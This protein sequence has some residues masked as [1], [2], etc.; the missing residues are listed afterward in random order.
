VRGNAWKTTRLYSVA[1]VLVICLTPAARGAVTFGQLDDFQDGTAMGWAEGLNTTSPNPPINMATG[2]R[3]GAG[4]RFLQ[5]ASSGGFGA[6]SKQIMFNEGR[7][8]G[9]YNAARV[10][11][12][13]GWMANAGA[14]TLRV[15]VAL[16]GAGSRF[17]STDPVV[18]APR[19]NQSDPLRWIPVTFDLT[20]GA[21]T[22]VMGG[23][24]L[25]TARSNVTELRLLSSASPSFFGDSLVSALAVDDLRALHLQ[26]DTDF[27]GRVTR[28]EL[29][30][31]R[32]NMG[33]TGAT[34]QTGD[35]N[36]DGRVNALDMALLRRNF[37]SSPMSPL[38]AA[39]IVPE[40]ACSALPLLM[41]FLL[42]RCRHTRG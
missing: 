8:A 5:N 34:W 14:S 7:W 28:A 39:S 11:R 29:A 6:G 30:L 20:A 16:D 35:F 42:I 10:T 33:S 38:G 3:R 12:I 32:S 9:N 13:T 15:R 37:S 23:G 19:A 4:D 21:M 26:G 40:P 24:N 36:F 18:L 31:V 1:T 17:A 22:D 2:G 25:N 41:A 27:D